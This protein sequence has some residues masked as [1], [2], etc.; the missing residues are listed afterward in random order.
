MADLT[1]RLKSEKIDI[2]IETLN[3]HKIRTLEDMAIVCDVATI[4]DLMQMFRLPRA[5]ASRLSLHFTSAGRRSWNFQPAQE[6]R[7]ED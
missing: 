7:H 4:D 2:S 1:D 6:S 5:K 3:T